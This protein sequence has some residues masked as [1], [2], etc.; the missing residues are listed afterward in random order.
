MARNFRRQR[1][2]H[3]IAEL[4]VT[5]LIDLGFTL[6]IIFMISAP[7]MIPEQTIPVDLPL[8]QV[9]PQ[10]KANPDDSFE[11]LTFLSDGS[12]FLGERRVTLAQINQAFT[13]FAAR[14]RPPIIR[15]RGEK[16]APWQQVVNVLD[17][18]QNHQLQ[19]LSIDTE[20]S[21]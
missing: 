8:Q 13:E 1:I 18:M 20:I 16:T 7:L 9:R 15:L 6:L 11:D 17:A 2:A 5:N 3:P 12:F 19:Q 4:N 21:N 14:P 10:V